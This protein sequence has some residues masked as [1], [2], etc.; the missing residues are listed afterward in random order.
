M[1]NPQRKHSTV[2]LIRLIGAGVLTCAFVYVPFHLYHKSGFAKCL[3]LK[4]EHAELLKAN[5]ALQDEIEALQREASALQGDPVA[6]E[7]VARHE[8]GW[9]RPGDLLIDLSERAP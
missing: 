9:V 6:V 1:G 5:Q 3:E 4:A 7:R 8:L 2:W